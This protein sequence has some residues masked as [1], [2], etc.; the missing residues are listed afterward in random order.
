MSAV[1][2]ARV[3]GPCQPQRC[4][5]RPA[6][7]TP[8]LLLAIVL[9]A[10]GSAGGARLRDARLAVRWERAPFSGAALRVISA[11]AGAQ[12][13]A[14]PPDASGERVFEGLTSGLARIEL[15]DADDRVLRS[16]TITL[17]SELTTVVRLDAGG[18]ALDVLP[19]N[20]DPFGNASIWGAR[21]LRGLPGGVAG[22]LA[23]ELPAAAT[24]WSLDGATHG[25]STRARAPAYALEE[26][27]AGVQ[28]PLGTAPAFLAPAD[29][30][31][32]TGRP[33]DRRGSVSVQGGTG[34]EMSG[35]AEL[36]AAGRLG[37]AGPFEFDGRFQGRAQED[38]G[39]AGIASETLEENDLEELATRLQAWFRPPGAGL[40]RAAFHAE[41]SSR[42]HYLHEFRRN[43]SHNPQQDRSSLLGSLDWD[44][45]LGPVELSAG[46]AYTRSYSETGD[47]VAYDRISNYVN[48]FDENLETTEDGLYWYGGSPAGPARPHL[49]NYYTQD[50]TTSWSAHGEARALLA[51]GAPLRLGAEAQRATWRWYEHLDPIADASLP[52][53]SPGGFQ[54][55]SYLGYQRD[56]GDHADEAFHAAPQPWQAAL[57]AD[58]RLRLGRLDLE[59]GLRWTTFAPDQAPLRD[60]AHPLGG[61]SELT[62]AALDEKQTHANVDPAIGLHVALGPGTHLW[63]DAGSRHVPPPLEALYYSANVLTQLALGPQTG[64]IPDLPLAEYVI[65]G[66]PA[67]EPERRAGLSAAVQQAF[68]PLGHVRVT[69]RWEEVDDVWVVQR[70]GGNSADA[71]SFYGNR[72][73]RRERGVRI[74]LTTPFLASTS[75]RGSYT[76]A[77]RETNVIEPAPLYRGL[78]LPDLPV[79]GNGAQETAAIFPLWIDDGADRDW[80]PSLLDRRHR[81][82]VA[83]T[84]RVG[85]T[86]EETGLGPIFNDLDVTASLRAA[87]GAPYTPT[88]LRPE[89][90]LSAAGSDPHPGLSPATP[91]DPNGDG[92]LDADEINSER[93]PWSWSIDV[94]LRRPFR[95]LGQRFA[96]SAEMRNVLNRKN[97]RVVYGATGEAD[98]D[99]WLATAAGRQWLG[100][101]AA[102]AE[103]RRLAYEERLDD[104]NRYEAGRSVAA[105]LSWE[106]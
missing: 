51:P 23:L 43:A 72:G 5:F 90:L 13:A 102:V 49:Y 44:L 6:I 21:E 30:R 101:N 9:L 99:G 65:F 98:D 17:A 33:G 60:L 79:E 75:L 105:R 83:W 78:L 76:L 1:S 94:G 35:W 63:A 28:A 93:M 69:G 2:H 92:R 82:A 53:G 91:Y 15:R 58:Q 95:F 62:A 61:A 81:V 68:G 31:V 74:D 47:G 66:N 77:S 16:W 42:R 24:A 89:G 84:A 46:A 106:F 67:L 54:L 4:R 8:A 37:D 38:A 55:A 40:F 52:P 96:V 27:A 7:A 26:G 20:P 48:N 10:A 39:P 64:R 71:L 56:G 36:Q 97:P 11:G 3:P 14:L 86:A 59:G 22:A 85:E 45:P 103:E 87:S 50:L 57:W 32:L 34:E 88:N 29:A 19:V 104:P 18:P 80:F 25:P 73:E 70:P 100:A 12:Q 41:G